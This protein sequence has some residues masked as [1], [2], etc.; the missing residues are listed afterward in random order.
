MSRKTKSSF[1]PFKRFEI[2][3]I[4]DEAII[5]FGFRRILQISEGG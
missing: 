1:S 5:E 3:L 2:I 4:N